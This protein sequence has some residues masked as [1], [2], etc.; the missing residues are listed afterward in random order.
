MNHEELAGA[1]AALTTNE[2]KALMMRAADERLDFHKLV[3]KACGVVGE[4]TSDQ[5]RLSKQVLANWL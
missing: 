3:L 4:I 1:L 5:R 2:L